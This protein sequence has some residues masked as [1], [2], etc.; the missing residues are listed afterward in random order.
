M[1]ASVDEISGAKRKQNLIEHADD[2]R[3]SKMLATSSATSR[4]TST[5]RPR[6]AHEPDRSRLREVFREFELRAPL[7]RLE[8]FVRGAAAAPDGGAG[9]RVDGR[10]KVRE[11]S[12]ADIARL[13]ERARRRRSRAADPEGELFAETDSW[14]FARRLR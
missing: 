4:S 11:G 10:R 8:D 9:R 14:R 13:G 7:Q 5:R 3:V 12:L 1:L 6:P 2:A